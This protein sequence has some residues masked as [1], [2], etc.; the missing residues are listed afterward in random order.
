M[1]GTNVGGMALQRGKSFV[2]LVS[3]LMSGSYVLLGG[4]LRMGLLGNGVGGTII[5]ESPSAG[6]SAAY[7]LMS[8]YQ[9]Q[10][11]S[12]VTEME[13]EGLYSTPTGPWGNSMSDLAQGLG[14]SLRALNMTVG[15][16]PPPVTM[17]MSTRQ[18]ALR[19]ML[20]ALGGM[21]AEDR[22]DADATFASQA[23]APVSKEGDTRK[24]PQGGGGISIRAG[25]GSP[26]NLKLFCFVT[27]GTPLIYR[28]FVGM[29]KG[30]KCFCILT[31]C[32]LSHNKK[33]FD[34][35][36]NGDYYIIKSGGHGVVS[37]QPFRAFFK[38]LLPKVAAEYSPDNKE[39]AGGNKLNGRVA[40]TILLSD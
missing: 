10:I 11:I 14:S 16:P 7:K 33:I 6:G 28:G 3:S 23:M 20:G 30:P 19:Q 12:P 39:S 22:V 9:D 13:N 24:S 15:T 36:G 27:K 5:V 2:L 21:V 40:L 1:A 31:H 29:Q 37:S 4:L 35:L 8:G 38:P 17:G 32:G 26:A 34:R 25:T 18:G